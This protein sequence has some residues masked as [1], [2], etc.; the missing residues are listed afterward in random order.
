MAASKAMTKTQVVGHLADKVGI[1]KKQSAQ[2]L[3]ELSALAYKQAKNGFT[4]PGI[5]KLVVQ[6]R[7]AR[8]GIVPFGPRKG[9]KYTIP[10]RRVL[11]FRVA[12]AAKDAVTPP[13]K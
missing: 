11:K 3:E 8:K 5:G 9:E 6:Q 13:K 12:K 4:L 1:T 10:A 7:K 2:Y